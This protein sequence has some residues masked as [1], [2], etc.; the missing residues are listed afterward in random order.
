MSLSL[1][2]M[3]PV[4]WGSGQPA[5]TLADQP[6]APLMDRP[7][8]R[9]A[10]QRQVGQIGRAAMQPVAQM[11]GFTPG[12]GPRTAGEHTATITNRQGGA[13]GGLDDPAGPADLQRLGGCATQ[14]RRQ[15]RHRRPQPHPQPLPARISGHRSFIP[16]RVPGQRSLIPARGLSHRSLVAARGLG[17]RSFVGAGAV[18]GVAVA[19]GVAGDEDP[20]Q[21]P[22]TSQPPTRLRIQRPHPATLPPEA[23]RAANQAVQVHRHH[24]L[25][26]DPAGLGQPPPSKLRRANSASASAR[27]WPPLRASSASAGRANG[28]NAATKL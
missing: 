8:M 6:P 7:M 18:V 1:G 3:G 24:Q 26:A 9:P 20:G 15:Q 2:P 16:A 22:V 21:R 27:R 14:D 13:L 23:A 12:Q 28:S 4:G 10:Q 17:R 25:R 5:I 11:M 19:A